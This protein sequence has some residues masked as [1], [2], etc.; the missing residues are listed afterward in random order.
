VS[1]EMESS[2]L[3]NS[4]AAQEFGSDYTDIFGVRGFSLQ[5]QTGVVNGWNLIVRGAVDR[6]APLSVH[7][8][9]ASGRYE[10]TIPAWDLRERVV[11]A[12]AERP[13]WLAPGGIEA[14][15]RV[16]ADAIG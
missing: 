14:Q 13:T 10:P 3:K 9:P 1:D 2:L 15:L 8:K 4:I 7:A 12:V 6:T 16:Q 5:A 11:S